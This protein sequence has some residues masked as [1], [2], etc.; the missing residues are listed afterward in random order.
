[1]YPE[2]NREQKQITVWLI[3]TVS[4]LV[5]L[6]GST[7]FW[8]YT[9][10]DAFISFRYCDNMLQGN[11]LVFNQNQPV[12]GYTNFLWIMLI[13]IP[14]LVLPFPLAAKLPGILL[15]LALL[16]L[17]ARSCKK[18]HY[19]AS[20][21]AALI[22]A[23]CPGVQMW[24]VAGLETIL[25]TICLVAGFVFHQKPKRLNRLAAG[26]CFGLATLTRPEGA[27]FFSLFIISI[28]LL[29][30]RK[31][32]HLLEYIAGFTLMV[33]PH[34]CFRLAY[35]DSWVPNTFWVKS[36]RFQGGGAD[37]FIRY[38]AMTGVL[39]APLA[40][41]G[42]FVSYI[43][44]KT[45]PLILMSAGYV[46]Y[47][48]M[49]GGDWMPY[50]RFLIP[51]LPLLAIAATNTVFG[52]KIYWLRYTGIVILIITILISGISAKYDIIRQRETHYRDILTWEAGHMKDWKRIALWFNDN[53]KADTVLCT[54]LAGVIPYYSE[55]PVLDRGGLN[56]REI[57]QVIYSAKN[58]EAED[59]KIDGII[60]ERQPGIVMIE[61]RSFCMVDTMP[62]T[63][64][65]PPVKLPKFFT[66]YTLE[67]IALDS[68]YFAFF[69]HKD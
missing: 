42:L 66:E 57:A 28:F 32:L 22:V 53:M 38:A 36:K 54:G 65:S 29:N 55:L 69:L 17:M 26:I 8:V 50:G 11:G 49:I 15:G 59:R 44:E 48:F 37:Y 43:R 3:T 62:I 34:L 30:P 12:E 6:V 21:S 41:V 58:Q 1:M 25:F 7:G 52:M 60:M 2:N 24:S 51:V 31:P 14:R 16:L 33:L 13:S 56:D 27:L 46:F 39:S 67:N 5:F 4:L 47:V 18:N 35:Y 40:I 45:L 10:E 19:L 9:V 20:P 63:A 61:E 64:V 23:V 68:G